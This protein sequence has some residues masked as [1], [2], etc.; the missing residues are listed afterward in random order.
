MAEL[1]LLQVS[2]DV[3]HWITEVLFDVDSRNIHRD[4]LAIIGRF[5]EC[6]AIKEQ[7]YKTFTATALECLKDRDDQFLLR[8]YGLTALLAYQP[9]WVFFKDNTLTVMQYMTKHLTALTDIMQRGEIVNYNDIVN[10]AEVL[11]NTYLSFATKFS[12]ADEL[13]QELVQLAQQH[14]KTVF[15]L[16]TGTT[17]TA[18]PKHEEAPYCVIAHKVLNYLAAIMRSPICSTDCNYSA[19]LLVSLFLRNITTGSTD[20]KE[21]IRTQI[22]HAILYN[23]ANPSTVANTTSV[24]QFFVS[25]DCWIYGKEFSS[26]TNVGQLA[27]LKGTLLALDGDFDILFA[28]TK[29]LKKRYEGLQWRGI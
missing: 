14:N 22:V 12:V 17:L 29:A 9:I 26:F 28:P 25:N 15:E 16:L 19:G 7:V 21:Q 8:L 2:V 20:D 24:L 6:T 4:L 23:Y 13:R 10:K 11:L 1:E 27:V 5:M 3:T 18:L